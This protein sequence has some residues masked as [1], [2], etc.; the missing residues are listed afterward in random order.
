M[1]ILNFFRE[2]PVIGWLVLLGL[3]VIVVSVASALWQK[4]AGHSPTVVTKQSTQLTKPVRFG[5]QTDLVVLFFGIM[6]LL[7][8]IA[9]IRSIF[10]G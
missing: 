2:D 6:L 9:W 5:N 10:F 3:V 8:V 4:M 1:G 7:G